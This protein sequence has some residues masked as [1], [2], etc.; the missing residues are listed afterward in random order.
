MVFHA[1]TEIT[2]KGKEGEKY[3]KK[4]YDNVLVIKND[5]YNDF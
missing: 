3:A 5:S 4:N 1:S 2:N